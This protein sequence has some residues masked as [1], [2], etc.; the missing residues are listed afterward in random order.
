MPAYILTDETL[1][2]DGHTLKRIK[3]VGHGGKLGGWVESTANLISDDGLEAWISGE[4]KCY[5]QGVV[6]ENGNMS[7]Q[8]IN[9]GAVI[10][11]NGRMSGHSVATGGIIGVNGALQFNATWSSGVLTS[12]IKNV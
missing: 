4:A 6:K 11:S 5:G 1:E 10:Q 9:S 3:L 8:A 2:H 12:T 7:G